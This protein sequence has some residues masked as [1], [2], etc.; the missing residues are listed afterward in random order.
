MTMMKSDEDAEGASTRDEAARVT[1][2]ASKVGALA[3]LASRIRDRLMMAERL[4]DDMRLNGSSDDNAREAAARAYAHEAHG[5]A[6]E[7]ARS[8]LWAEVL[9]GRIS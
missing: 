1:L 8:P 4:A 5:A 2:D 6:L 3:L 7:L 9:E